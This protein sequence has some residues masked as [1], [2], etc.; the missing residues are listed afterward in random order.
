MESISNIP[1]YIWLLSTLG[2]FVFILLILIILLYL[3]MKRFEKSY[4]SLQTFMNGTN[5]DDILNGFVKNVENLE[6]AVK[7]CNERLEPMELKLRA[8]IDRAE[9][10]RFRAFEDVGSD[11]SFAIALLN[12][13]GDGIVISSIH[14]RAEARI[15]AKPVKRGESTYLLSDEEKEVIKKAMISQRV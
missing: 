14:S 9:L 12:Q 4:L 2:L 8:S 13:E 7:K 1:Q 10:L 11:L 6:Q 3:R 15:Y 5:M